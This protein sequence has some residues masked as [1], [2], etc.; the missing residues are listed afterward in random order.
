MS[1]SWGPP[2]KP[3][4][5]Q[6]EINPALRGIGENDNP[7]HK[8]VVR[9]IRESPL[10]ACMSAVRHSIG[11]WIFFEIDRAKRMAVFNPSSVLS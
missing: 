3:E 7:S 2:A 10:R 5:Y 6:N 4:V 9:A 8:A 1:N 11:H